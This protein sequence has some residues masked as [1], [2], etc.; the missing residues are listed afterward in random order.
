MISMKF[1]PKFRINDT[2]IGSDDGL[3]PGRPQAIIWTND[4]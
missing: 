4:G 1:V 2:S 3:A